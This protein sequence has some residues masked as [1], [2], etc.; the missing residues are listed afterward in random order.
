MPHLHKVREEGARTI[1]DA[2]AVARTTDDVRV[3]SFQR[4]KNLRAGS[5][6]AGAVDPAEMKKSAAAKPGSLTRVDDLIEISHVGLLFFVFVKF[7]HA[8]STGGHDA[9]D[10]TYILVF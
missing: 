10:R 2:H 7:N 5:L 3:V 8:P 9:H 4:G 6:P 1:D